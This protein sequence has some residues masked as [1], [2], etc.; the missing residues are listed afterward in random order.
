MACCRQNGVELGSRNTNRDL[1]ICLVDGT[2]VSI[3]DDRIGGA[4]TEV[5]YGRAVLITRH[6][7]RIGAGLDEELVAIV[8]KTFRV[9]VA[10]DVD[11]PR[12]PR[13]GREIHS[14]RVY[15]RECRDTAAPHCPPNQ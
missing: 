15:G 2:K 12:L 1:A 6:A 8:G 9:G 11:D 5:T 3:S 13:V 10:T 14:P 4:A 7:G